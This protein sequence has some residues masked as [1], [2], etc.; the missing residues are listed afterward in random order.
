MGKIDDLADLYERHVCGSWQRTL[1]GAQRVVF[2]VYDKENERSLRARTSDFEQ[3]TVHGKHAWN[4]CDCTAFFASWMAA[5]EYRE[6]Y[7]EQPDDLA[8]KLDGEF[9]DWVADKV[10]TRLQ[11]ADDNTVVALTGLGALYPFVHVHVLIRAVEPDIKGRLLVFF[12]GSKNDNNYRL[13]DARDG[14]HYLGTSITLQGG[15]A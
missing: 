11:A 8:L 13:L 6:A 7:F 14:F 1:A 10:R 2:V 9:L 12:P 5:D 4:E 15:A 3:R